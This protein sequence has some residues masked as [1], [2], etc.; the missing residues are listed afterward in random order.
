[1]QDNTN[2]STVAVAT[3]TPQTPVHVT[4]VPPKGGDTAL[5]RGV[6]TVIQVF[7]GTVVGL[8]VAIWQVPGVPQATTAYLTQHLIDIAASIGVS[9]GLIAFLWNAARPSVKNF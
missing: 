3:A 7:G 6:R 1:M 5:V 4:V 8:F 9:S 2:T